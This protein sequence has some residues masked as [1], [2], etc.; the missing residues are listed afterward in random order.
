MCQR[1][2]MCLT[3]GHAT[4]TATFIA[5][6]ESLAIIYGLQLGP[7]NSFKQFNADT[8][9]SVVSFAIYV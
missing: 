6:A 8:Y 5:L 9:P 3:S 2:I 1:Q 4:F 7:S